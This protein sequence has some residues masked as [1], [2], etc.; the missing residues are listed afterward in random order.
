MSGPRP[1][2]GSSGAGGKQNCD[3]D[4]IWGDLKQGIDEVRKKTGDPDPWILQAWT[5]FRVHWIPLEFAALCSSK[6]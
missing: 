5:L 1:G 4:Q 2:N 6:V 3:L